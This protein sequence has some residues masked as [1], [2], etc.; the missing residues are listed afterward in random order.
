MTRPRKKPAAPNRSLAPADAGYDA[1]RAGIAELLDQARRAAA[2]AVN[3]VLTATYW[4]VGRR[5]VEHEQGGHARAGYGEELL[6]RLGADLSKAFGRGFSAR[7]LRKMRAFYQGW[8]IWPTPSAKLSARVRLPVSGGGSGVTGP[9]APP[10]VA[11]LADAFPLPWSHYVRLM[12]VPDDTPRAFYE[13]EAVRGGWSVRQLDR[14]IATQFYERLAHSKDRAKMLRRGQEPKP[15]D[16]VAVTDMVRDP[17][18]LEFLDLTDE[19]AETDL[20]DALVKHLEQF[21]LELGNGFTFVARQKRILIDTVWYK[22]DLVL[23]HRRLRCLVV[24]DLKVG[25]F[26]HADAGQIN[27]YL[28]Y[29][30]EHL[31]EPGEA[32]P[33]GIILCSE[34]SDTVVRYATAGI[35]AQV[36]ASRYQT[37][38]PPAEELR[39]EVERTRNAL[40]ARPPDDG[41]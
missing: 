37:A 38:L 3:G 30:K 7:G 36:F 1:F 13:E 27:L 14:Q 23:F 32:D 35:N 34:K 2:R 6:A 33:I 26:S 24:I 5:I 25:K 17:Y 20:E 12:S 31:T 40:A 15:E 11:A 10:A 21:L 28:N 22:M 9:A 4:E 16:A 39:Q 41:R 18:L 8:E 29:A 19:Y